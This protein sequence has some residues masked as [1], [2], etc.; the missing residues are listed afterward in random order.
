[1]RD[2]AGG[3]TTWTLLD[4]EARPTRARSLWDEPSECKQRCLKSNSVC[5]SCAERRRT[6]NVSITL[7]SEENNVVVRPERHDDAA[8]GVQS[9]RF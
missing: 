8:A 2:L 9:N 5:V 6:A 4:N 7:S 3:R 1:M